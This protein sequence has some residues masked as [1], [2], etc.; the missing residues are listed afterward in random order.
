MT[1]EQFKL[2]MTQEYLRQHAEENSLD[3]LCVVLHLTGGS[4]KDLMDMSVT[5]FDHY[6]EMINNKEKARLFFR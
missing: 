6:A 3:M 2:Q 4:E 5:M 1:P